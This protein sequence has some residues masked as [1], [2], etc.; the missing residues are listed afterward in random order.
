MISNQEIQVFKILPSTISKIAEKLNVYPGTA[1]KITE[2]LLKNG[3]A[4]KRIRLFLD[5]LSGIKI[6][7]SGKDL[8]NLELKPGP[9]FKDI[10]QKVLYAKIDGKLK[11]KSAELNYAKQILANYF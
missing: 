4:K 8:K 2:K 1:S 9:K 10:L 5:K 6:E 11:S 3:L 7:M